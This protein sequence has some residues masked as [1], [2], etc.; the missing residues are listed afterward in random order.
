MSKRRSKYAEKEGTYAIQRS[1][2]ESGCLFGIS[3][4]ENPEQRELIRLMNQNDKPI[5]FC[6]GD[7][8]TGKTFTAVA[9]AL[10]LVKVRKKYAKIFYIREPIE[11]G[12]RSLGFLP[13]DL[14][15]KY[16]V[17]LNG[18][19]DNIEHISEMS[20]LNIND[21]R[22]SIECIPPQFIRGRSFENSILLV[23]EAQDLNLDEIQAISTRL[24]KYCKLVFLGSLKQ[25]DNK[26]M[27]SEKNDFLLSYNILSESLGDIVGKVDLVK[28]ER[29]EYCKLLDEAFNNYRNNL[30]K[31]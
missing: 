4:K 3:F 5:I 31:F 13:G 15:D 24:G 28:S 25:I 9:A 29:S 26:K 7:A 10:D 18:L 2:Y 19:Q 14:D 8:G 6:F 21:M 20:G 17:Y 27:T 11:V 30:K 16:G 12:S 22:M 23:D 1:S